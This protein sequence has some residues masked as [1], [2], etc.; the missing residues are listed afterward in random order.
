[1]T[2]LLLNTSFILLFVLSFPFIAFSEET[3]EYE[4]MWPAL[5]G[6]PWYFNHPSGIAVDSS[7]NVYLADT[8]NHR[9]Q[10]FSSNGQFVTRWGS[11][12]SGDGQFGSPQGIALDSSGNVYIADEW[13]HRIQKFSSNGQFIAKWGSN[14]SGD[15]QFNWP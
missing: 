13:N 14:G 6:Q 9:I 2:K 8:D 11:Q 1:M 12:G 15:G 7:G 10:K 3:Y 4:K 5:L